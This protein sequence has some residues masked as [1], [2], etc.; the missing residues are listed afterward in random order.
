MKKEK[1]LVTRDLNPR[2]LNHRNNAYKFSFYF[3]CFM[4]ISVFIAFF[5][6]RSFYTEQNCMAV[7]TTM[8]HFLHY[9]S[10]FFCLTV[11][12]KIYLTSISLW[13]IYYLIFF[14]LIQLINILQKLLI[15]LTNNHSNRNDNFPG[16]ICAT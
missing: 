16:A 1:L 12:H 14:L 13:K 4:K 5:Q 8:V 2:T 11:T 15:K 7:N 6:C 9:H 3:S 10:L